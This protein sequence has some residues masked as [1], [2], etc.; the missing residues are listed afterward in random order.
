M[1][2]SKHI[3]THN[4]FGL[5]TRTWLCM[6]VLGLISLGLLSYKIAVHVTCDD[7]EITVNAYSAGAANSYY[8]GEEIKFIANAKDAKAT[9][10]D[11]GDK[12]KANGDTVKHLF[13]AEGT[14][15][16]TATANGKCVQSITISIR[17]F[18][19]QPATNSIANIENPISC[20]DIIHARTP[21]SFSSNI[22]A[23]TYE[24]TVLNTPEFPAQ[25]SAIATFIF[26]T[27]GTR[28]IELKLDGNANK[29]FR[30]TIQ[31][32]APVEAPA[33]NPSD[34]AMPMPLAPPP[35]PK[36]DKTALDKPEKPKTV[37][38]PNEEFVN[39]L[40][41]AT[42][43]QK[44]VQSF[45]QFLCD[46]ANTK[47]LTNGTDWETLGSFHQKIYGKK[48]YDIKSVDVVRD[49]NNCVKIL[50]I[51]YKKRTLGIF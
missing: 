36:E 15:I 27:P 2:D 51:K 25:N 14:Y 21:I 29:T 18:N 22:V 34:V 26:P 24:W 12:T 6:L 16:V 3:F 28:M 38:I 8:M 30:K 9:E 49:E 7:F 40:N 37:V 47:V 46:G 4:R 5:D 33:T 44:D 50:K 45:N 31:V 19:K 23:D 35:M 41:E 48:R 11:F 1:N 32:L 42:E 17:Q 43:G 20:P 13:L 39:M 10:W